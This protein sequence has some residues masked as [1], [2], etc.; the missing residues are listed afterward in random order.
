MYSDG[1][2]D[3]DADADGHDNPR[4]MSQMMWSEA[5]GG[6]MDRRFTVYG[7]RFTVHGSRF[8]VHGSRFTVHGS[9]FTVHGSRFTVHSSQFTVYSLR[10]TV[11]SLQLEGRW[12][13]KAELAFG[14]L[15]LCWVDIRAGILNIRLYMGFGGLL[16]LCKLSA[17]MAVMQVFFGA[18]KFY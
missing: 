16:V 10:F 2:S 7:S 9:R 17:A 1:D 6:M 3:A 5:R 12:R 15:R 4:S 11:Y 18:G 8:T 13:G 14:G